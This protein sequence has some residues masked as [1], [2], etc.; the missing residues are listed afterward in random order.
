MKALLFLPLAL[1]LVAQGSLCATTEAALVPGLVATEY[2]RHASQAD[3]QHNFALPLDQLGDPVGQ[4]FI[5]E[6]LSP[7]KWETER[8]AVARGV[9]EIPA[10]GD[11]RF[12]T[13]SFYDRNLLMIDDKV[14]CA[15]GDGDQ[16]VA[17]IPLKKGFVSIVSAGFVG[18]R[19]ASGIQVRWQPPDQRELS[20]IPPQ[21]LKHVDDGTVKPSCSPQ[22]VIRPH[23]KG[24]LATYLITV[25]DDFI[26]EA[27]KNGTRI[28]DD[29][30]TLLDEI[31]G[32]TAERITVEVKAGDWLVFHVVNNRQRWDG[33]KYFAVAGCLGENDFGFVSDPGS[34]DWSVCDD[35]SRARD[36]IRQRED[37]TEC[38]AGAIAK[39]W[40]DGD[41]TI[42]KQAGAGFPGKP[43]WGGSNS[44]WIKFIAPNNSPKLV[45][46]PSTKPT[47]PFEEIAPQKPAPPAT[48]AKAV[49]NP[50]RWP[51]QIIYAM[52]GSGDRNADV[53]L[54]LKELVEKQKTSF[55]VNPST[56]GADPIPYWR[57]SLWIAFAKDGVRHE[58][59]RYED[60]V[61]PPEYFYGPQSAG[62]LDKWLP[63]S[64][65]QSEKGELQFY[66][67]HTTFGYPFG[68]IPQWEALAN[69][70]IR[71]TWTD[72][73]KVDYL[74]DETWS[75]FH[76][77]DDA[78]AVFRIV[79]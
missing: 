42:R 54:R 57:K 34:S 23:P 76:E 66:P 53:T 22:M 35:P 25:A 36:F 39:P 68:G 40:S 49:L 69:N 9:L 79:E 4:K 64:R 7:W 67:D 1:G 3:D 10:D 73:R 55:A 62:E 51:V 75:S 32:A 43:L 2:P 44:T 21:F 46:L 41:A 74:F 37:G 12:T 6:C 20:A 58:V 77:V 78:K 59:R 72:E 45:T 8:N 63:G 50:T 17:T 33:A 38:R 71:I 11:Y 52:W 28:R 16:T 5:V 48:S 13:S 14:V 70:K 15:L 29:Q 30:R 60:E 27:Y 47:P 18:G 19:G 31:H 65:W 24:L 26:V 56:L 61:V